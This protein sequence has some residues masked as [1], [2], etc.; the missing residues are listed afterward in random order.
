MKLW[1]SNFTFEQ[2][3]QS[4][5]IQAKHSN[6][7]FAIFVQNWPLGQ[8]KLWLHILGCISDEDTLVGN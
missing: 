8:A 1:G 7:I 6:I 4:A 2:T 3:L 5:K